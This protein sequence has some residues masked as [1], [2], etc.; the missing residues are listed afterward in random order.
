MLN[1]VNACILVELQVL[2]WL[3]PSKRIALSYIGIVNTERLRVYSTTACSPTG[4]LDPTAP[5]P[6]ADIC[7]IVEHDI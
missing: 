4:I 7:E 2:R 1:P 3:H 6:V 5:S